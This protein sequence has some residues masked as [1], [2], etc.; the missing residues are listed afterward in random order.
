MNSKLRVR[1]S[2]LSHNIDENDSKK[3]RRYI[4]KIL[5]FSFTVLEKYSYST[6][7]SI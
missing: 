5:L 2:I 1:I 7:P 4:D 3:Q 6:N